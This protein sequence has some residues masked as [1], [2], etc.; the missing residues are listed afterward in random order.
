MCQNATIAC[1]PR[2]QRARRPSAPTYSIRSVQTSSRQNTRKT[3]G[4]SAARKLRSGRR[5]RDCPQLYFK[6]AILIATFG[7]TYAMLVFVAH[8]WW[9]GVPL[10]ILLGLA[11]NLI[12][13]LPL[14]PLLD[15]IFRFG[16]SRRTRRS[17]AMRMRR[18]W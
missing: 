14:F 13:S 6:A 3:G 10:A 4:A 5:Q 1:S 7:A 2:A 12:V 8:T 9:L 18:R 15:R 17:E 11:V 16:F